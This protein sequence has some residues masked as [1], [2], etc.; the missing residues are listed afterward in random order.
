MLDKIKTRPV[1]S[2]CAF[3]DASHDWLLSARLTCN[4]VDTSYKCYCRANAQCCRYNKRYCRTNSAAMR[5]RTS[6]KRFSLPAGLSR[7]DSDAHVSQTLLPAGL[8]H[9]DSDMHVSQ[10]LLIPCRTN[11]PRCRCVHLANVTH[12]LQNYPAT[13]PIRTSCKHYSHP[14]GLTQYDTVVS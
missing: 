5:I 14:A 11:P 12:F 13:I 7:Y 6:C 9:Y 1:K 2:V 3:A 10:S 8:T 4:D